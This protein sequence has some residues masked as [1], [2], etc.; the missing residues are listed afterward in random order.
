VSDF[1]VINAAGLTSIEGHNDKL[2][3]FGSELVEDVL[4]VIDSV[5]AVPGCGNNTCA[6]SGQETLENLNTNTAFTD[7]GKKC[8]LLGEGDTRGGNLSQNVKVCH[9]R[10][11]IKN[12]SQMLVSFWLYPQSV[13][14]F[15]FKCRNGRWASSTS[16]LS[17]TFGRKNW[18][19][20]RRCLGPR[21]RVTAALSSS[22]AD[23]LSSAVCPSDL[24][25]SPYIDLIA[26]FCAG[27]IEG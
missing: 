4:V 24:T 19:E 16:V 13:P 25:T 23:E 11:L 2:G 18:D 7:T 20:L 12:N 27:V 9:Q 14:V 21:V 6:T 17:S 5:P 8:S 26:A 22:T 1:G 3:A 10:G 15:R